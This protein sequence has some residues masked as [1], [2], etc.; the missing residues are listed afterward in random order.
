MTPR[1][2]V[3][4]GTDEN[5]TMGDEQAPAVEHKDNAD[6][7]FMLRASLTLKRIEK[8]VDLLYQLPLIVAALERYKT[9]RCYR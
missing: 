9:D 8:R 7:E 2:L 5:D 1:E 3:L 6:L 4:V